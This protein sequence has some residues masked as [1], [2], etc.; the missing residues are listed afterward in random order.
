MV[1]GR[2][3]NLCCSIRTQALAYKS[4]FREDVTVVRH[5]RTFY[6]MRTRE[7]ISVKD[8]VGEDTSTVRFCPIPQAMS[9]SASSVVSIDC[10][11]VYRRFVVPVRQHY[12]ETSMAA[13]S[14]SRPHTIT[15]RFR[16]VHH[17]FISQAD[18]L[19]LG[20]G[21]RLPLWW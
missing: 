6:P 14:V 16:D 4:V 11:M 21:A 9:M 20:I 19:D 3:F 5:Y 8:S 10:S 12:L 13:R 17:F 7:S 2:G 15:S 18:G 1:A